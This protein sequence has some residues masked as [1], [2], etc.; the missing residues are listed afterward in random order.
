MTFFRGKENAS[1]RQIDAICAMYSGF[2]YLLWM[3]SSP[4]PLRGRADPGWAGTRGLRH[5]CFSRRNPLSPRFLNGSLL[6]IHSSL[7]LCI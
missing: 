4:A 3:G 6:L 1:A 7:F 5:S 2:S